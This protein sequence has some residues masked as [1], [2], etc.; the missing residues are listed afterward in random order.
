MTQ[1]VAI[2]FHSDALLG[3]VT[4]SHKKFQQF[5]K[6]PMHMHKHE[7]TKTIYENDTLNPMFHS[8]F[9]THA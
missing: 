1:N 6:Y 7:Y 3:M 9:F 2:T 8:T 5:E 4:H